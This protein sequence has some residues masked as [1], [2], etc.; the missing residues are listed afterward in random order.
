MARGLPVLNLGFLPSFPP[1]LEKNR[2]RPPPWAA[3]RLGG[4]QPRLERERRKHDGFRESV[5]LHLTFP[6]QE[7]GGSSSMELCPG[8]YHETYGWSS[9]PLAWAKKAT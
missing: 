4:F 3:S 9:L 5:I 6:G 1:D 7:R 8:S 2:A